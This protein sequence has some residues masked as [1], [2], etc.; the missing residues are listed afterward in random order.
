MA[1]VGLGVRVAFGE[2]MIKS[3]KGK[4]EEEMDMKEFQPINPALCVTEERD[5]AR[6]SAER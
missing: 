4:K 5:E 2:K 1:V 3:L 6:H